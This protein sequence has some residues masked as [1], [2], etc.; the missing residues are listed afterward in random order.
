MSIT[1][2]NHSPAWDVDQW[3]KQSKRSKHVYR[4]LLTQTWQDL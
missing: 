2:E 1:T 4:K 3:N